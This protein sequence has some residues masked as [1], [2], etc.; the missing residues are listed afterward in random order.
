[1]LYLVIAAF[2]VTIAYLLMRALKR[3]LTSIFR[4]PALTPGPRRPVNRNLIFALIAVCAWFLF[5]VIYYH[6]SSQPEET[7]H[8]FTR[9]EG[10]AATGDSATPTGVDGGTRPA[11]GCCEW[12]A[13]F[14]REN[15]T[16]VEGFWRS[17]PDCA[18]GCALSRHSAEP[19]DAV[20]A[21]HP[22]A[23][24]SVAST[25]PLRSTGLSTSDGARPAEGCCEWVAPFTREN[26]TLV[27]GYWRSKPDCA[28][29][30]S[31]SKPAIE[32]T[33]VLNLRS[34]KPK[35]PAMS[36]RVAAI[37]ITA[38]VARRCTNQENKRQT[39][40]P[41][42]LGMAPVMGGDLS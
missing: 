7:M 18:G 41:G 8:P 28:G 14:T 35:P 2:V 26:G 10:S 3:R 9:P 25:V 4:S 37:I 1:M 5:G 31:L 20:P 17:K 32:T 11:D 40:G 38:R 39:G 15:G 6:H 22:E 23:P 12:V 24:P 42:F 33:V 21:P 29:G 34:S 13:P 36:G 27:D 19:T 30:C 16:R